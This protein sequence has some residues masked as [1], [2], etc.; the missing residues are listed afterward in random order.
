MFIMNK[1]EEFFLIKFISE[2]FIGRNKNKK[3]K[4]TSSINFYYDK[5]EEDLTI[6][7]DRIIDNNFVIF[8]LNFDIIDN[9]API[10][11][12]SLY[13]TKENLIND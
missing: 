9:F 6:N 12:L 1:Y 13:V 11:L 7:K 4:R 2:D 10:P 5:I 8:F 3:N